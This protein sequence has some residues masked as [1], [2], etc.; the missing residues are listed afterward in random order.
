MAAV[1]KMFPAQ[2]VWVEYDDASDTVTV[3]PDS[4]SKET[5]VC[6][7]NSKGKLKIVFLSPTGKETDTLTDTEECILTVGGS[8]HFKCF[9]TGPNGETDSPKNGGVIVVSPLRP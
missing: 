3:T 6:F 5:K 4:V 2:D 7:K 9:F 8:Y 1:P